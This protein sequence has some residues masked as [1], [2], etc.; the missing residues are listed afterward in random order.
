MSGMEER[1][2]RRLP[3]EQAG[4]CRTSHAVCIP[5]TLISDISGAVTDGGGFFH[6]E[7]C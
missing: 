7:R 2:L 6:F 5:Q 3:A 4:E 1:L